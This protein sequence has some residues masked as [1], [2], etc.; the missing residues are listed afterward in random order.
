MNNFHSFQMDIVIYIRK[1]VYIHISSP[2]IITFKYHA[3]HFIN[4]NLNI[5]FTQDDLTVLRCVD[6]LQVCVAS[7]NRGVDCAEQHTFSTTHSRTSRLH[8]TPKRVL[9]KMSL[10][11]QIISS[12]TISFLY[13]YPSCDSNCLWTCVRIRFELLF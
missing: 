9:P 6:Q 10:E 8:Q 5:Y 1:I 13:K 7:V 3:L 11:T 12:S 4:T 2:M